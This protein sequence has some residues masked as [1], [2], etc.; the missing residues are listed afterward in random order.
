MFKTLIR[1]S[2][3]LALGFYLSI[4]VLPEIL[5]V[6]E[7]VSKYLLMTPAFIWLIRS[8]NRWLLNIASIILGFL[9]LAIFF[10]I[11]ESF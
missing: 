2:L 9:E 1:N 4:Y 7:T 10:L 5:H 6:N 11:F 3:I 8:N